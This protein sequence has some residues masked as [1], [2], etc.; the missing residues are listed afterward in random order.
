[1]TSNRSDP[2]GTATG[3]VVQRPWGW[4]ETLAEGEG[5]KVKRLRLEP[6]QRLSRQRHHHRLEQWLVLA[7]S[8]SVEL[9]LPSA[10]PG[11]L[12]GEAEESQ[13]LQPGSFVE[14]APLTVHR[15]RAGGEGLEILEVQRGP[16]LEEDD[17]ERFADDY[18]RV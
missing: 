17:I 11:E 10:H 7:G 16:V 1:M 6:G 3:A 2:L 8:G 13:P 15:A 12:P 5:Y 14:I 9:G 18:G 4:F